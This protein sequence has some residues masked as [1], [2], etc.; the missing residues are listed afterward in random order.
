MLTDFQ[1]SFSERYISKFTLKSSL[2]IPRHLKHV[3]T[4]PCETL[5][6]ENCQQSETRIVI[7]DKLQGSVTRYLRFGRLFSTVQ[8]YY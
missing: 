3:A 8:I 5:M 2:I 6:S 7:N 1:N 4:L